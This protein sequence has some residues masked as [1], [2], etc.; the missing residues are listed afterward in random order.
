MVNDKNLENNV[1]IIIL[2]NGS[3]CEFV[4]YKYEELYM[5]W[6]KIVI[7]SICLCS[8]TVF[9]NETEKN[10]NPLVKLE[11][12]SQR[13]VI[14]IEQM[15]L[16]KL[17]NVIRDNTDSNIVLAPEFSSS[18]NLK[19]IIALPKGVITLRELL[20]TICIQLEGKWVAT[21]SSGDITI[22]PLKNTILAEGEVDGSDEDHYSVQYAGK[23]LRSVLRDLHKKSGAKIIMFGDVGSIK[24]EMM[25]GD[26][27]LETILRNI[28]FMYDLRLT[29]TSDGTYRIG[30]N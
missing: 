1:I 12:L 24:I 25:I 5:S 7:L 28:A 27:T 21:G 29:Y 2:N 9:A 13:V 17:L 20:D 4:T 30:K 18:E 10:T 22:N 23:T 16:N 19:K 14:N 6:S 3:L 11:P 8:C 26:A 15:D